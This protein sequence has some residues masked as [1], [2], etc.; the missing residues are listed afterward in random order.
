MQPRWVVVLAVCAGCGRLGEDPRQDCGASA[1]GDGSSSATPLAFVQA[2]YNETTS[3][4]INATFA[5]PQRAGD[6]VIVFVLAA[7]PVQAPTAGLSRS[8]FAEYAKVRV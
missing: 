7:V 4:G 5:L 1:L 2:N 6:I 8:G 3:S